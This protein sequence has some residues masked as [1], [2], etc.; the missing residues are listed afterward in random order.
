MF[1]LLLSGCRNYEYFSITVLEPGELFLPD[2]YQ[3]LLLLHSTPAD[4][5]A[6]R[7]TLYNIFDQVYYDSTDRSGALAAAAKNTLD[8][9]VEMV[10]SFDIENPDSIILH[11]PAD[12]A[13]FTE[14]HLRQL[15]KLCNDAGAEAIVLLLS[16]DK[17]VSYNI[18]FGDFGGEVGEFSV[19]MVSKWLLIDPFISKLIDS[20]TIRDTLYMTVKNPY[21]MSDSEN[22]AVSRQLLTEI[23]EQ[24]AIKYGIYLSPHYA[25]TERMV[26]RR[27]HR[28][29]RRG[30]K[31]AIDNNWTGAAVWWRKALPVQ[32]NSLRAMA[33]F[34]LAIANEMEGLLEPALEWAQTSYAYF[35][36]TLNGT[37]LRILRQRISQQKD[38]ILQ[39]EKQE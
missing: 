26:F 2:Q 1:V 33:S 22:L 28:Y 11:L 17:I 36:D 21:N 3:T 4:S 29:I 32:D 9:M 35:P 37:Y 7:G 31:E 30:Y 14:S 23:A 34:N 10:G 20:K 19:V 12:A 27:G 8:E 25:Q 5:V 13:D 15:R 38:I 39:M 16:I 6:G 18:Y 24:S